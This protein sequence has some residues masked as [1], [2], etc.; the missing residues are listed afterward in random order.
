MHLPEIA[1]LL[2]AIVAREK[3]DL[4]ERDDVMHDDRRRAPAKMMLATTVVATIFGSRFGICGALSALPGE[5]FSPASS[6]VRTPIGSMANS[7]IH[8]MMK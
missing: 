7:T 8:Q 4:V 6:E 3:R 5:V 2:H 1:A